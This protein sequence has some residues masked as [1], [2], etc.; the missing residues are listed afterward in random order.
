MKTTR[1]DLTRKKFGFLSVIRFAGIRRVGKDA[2]PKTLW[3]CRC[4]CGVKFIVQ[5][6]SLVSGNTRS[7]GCLGRIERKTPKE[8]KAWRTML[9]RCYNSN[10]KKYKDYGG[11]GIR[12]C[13]RWR[14]S[15]ENFLSDMGKAPSLRHSLDRKKVNGNYTPSNCKWS[16]PIE[17]GRNKRNTIR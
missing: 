12:V 13:R 8:E 7:C 9:W 3:T 11:R 14:N 5:G 1:N 4:T 15:F 2:Q 16:T 10:H 6:Q 17:Q